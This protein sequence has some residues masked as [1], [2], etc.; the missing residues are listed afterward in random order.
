M[1]RLYLDP[2]NLVC[3]GFE[4]PT[5]ITVAC[6]GAYMRMDTLMAMMPEGIVHNWLHVE[7]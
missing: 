7:I 5:N 3:L 2:I 6:R 1:S 4:T